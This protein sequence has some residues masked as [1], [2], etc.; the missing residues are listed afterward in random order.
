MI[1]PTSDRAGP[2]V[3][4]VVHDIVGFS[5]AYAVALVAAGCNGGCG[6]QDSEQ[7]VWELHCC[8]CGE[9]FWRGFR[10]RGVGWIVGSH[11]RETVENCTSWRCCC[12]RHIST[13]ARFSGFGRG[14]QL[15]CTP[16][17]ETSGHG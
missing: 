13:L 4:E 3:D 15:W 14:G 11:L 12:L 10:V 8:C 1:I 2:F 17:P 5:I 9:L 6:N 7:E 16:L